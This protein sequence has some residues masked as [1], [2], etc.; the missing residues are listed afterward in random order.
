V[1]DVFGV[2][3]LCSVVIV[4]AQNNNT[5][6]KIIPRS[7]TIFFWLL[8][9][10]V[11]WYGGAALY[12]VVRSLSSL[13][14]GY[15]DP[16]PTWFR[17][18]S[19]DEDA[20]LASMFVLCTAVVFVVWLRFYEKAEKVKRQAKRLQ[21]AHNKSASSPIQIEDSSDEDDPAC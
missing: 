16:Q 9:A 14:A 15:P 4:S 8:M 19:K 3:P 18:L 10:A 2:A 7:L 17:N 11:G 5:M 6:S 13:V 21:D 12:A 20:G 1:H